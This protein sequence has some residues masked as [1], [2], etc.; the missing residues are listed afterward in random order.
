MDNKVLYGILTLLFNCYGVPAFMQ[1]YTKAG[2]WQLVLGFVTCGIIATING[3]MGIIMGIKIL[4]MSDEEYA[5][6]DKST[7]LMGVPSPVAKKT[8]AE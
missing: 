7:L 1:G 2:V 8:D 3:I 4:M 5:A 6:A